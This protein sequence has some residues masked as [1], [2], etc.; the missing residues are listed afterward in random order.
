[1]ALARNADLAIDTEAF[2]TAVKAA[3]RSEDP[4]EC[5]RAA[6]LYGGEL[7]PDDRYVAWIEQPRE[8]LRLRYARL[9]KTG[10]LWERAIALDP[11]DEQAQCA[12][13][14]AALDAGNRGEAIRHFQ[15][16][17]E[18]LRIELGVGPK[19]ASIALYER[20][21]ATE[22]ASPA[23]VVDRV[24]ASLAWEPG[25]PPERRS[26]EEPQASP[27]RPERWPSRRS[28]RARWARP[29]RSSG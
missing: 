24:R 29:A 8:Q 18:R 17:R 16:L 20:A 3:L 5:E 12:L 19:A 22:G 10:K 14:Q 28:S 6:E 11:T 26:R 21:L 7:L 2:E 1:M 4:R 23:S 25:S 13:M 27:G 15:Q 9:L